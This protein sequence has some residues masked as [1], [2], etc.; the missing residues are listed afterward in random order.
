[1]ENAPGEKVMVDTDIRQGM[2]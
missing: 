2:G 1:M